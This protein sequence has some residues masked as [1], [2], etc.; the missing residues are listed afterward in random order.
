MNFQNHR[1]MTLLKKLDN[2][3]IPK[4]FCSNNNKNNFSEC[5][6]KKFKIYRENS[7]HVFQL[8]NNYGI[9]WNS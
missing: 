3:Q 7:P 9:P 1:L 8:K 5:F 6:P 4:S 2:C